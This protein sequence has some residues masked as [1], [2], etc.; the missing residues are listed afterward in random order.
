MYDL[1][2]AQMNMQC[3]LIWELY[4]FKVSHNATETTKNS[5][6]VKCEVA[7]DHSTVTRWLKKFCS[8]CKKLD[9]SA[10]SGRAENVDSE[11]MF[12]AIEANSLWCTWEISG[13]FGISQS[14]LDCYFHDLGKS[15]QSY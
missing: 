1:K 8:G 12:Q 4:E 11:A 9:H 6:C 5:C 13:K 7:I 14:S 10:R 2:A 15:M 3:S